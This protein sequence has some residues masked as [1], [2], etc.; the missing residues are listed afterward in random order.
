MSLFQQAEEH[1]ARCGFKASLHVVTSHASKWSSQLSSGLHLSHATG[2]ASGGKWRPDSTYHYHL[3]MAATQV[4]AALHFPM[5]G[6]EAQLYR[7]WACQLPPAP[8]R[9]HCTL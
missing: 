7:H 4:M 6:A 2:T 1:E 9:K 5:S 3:L 8:A